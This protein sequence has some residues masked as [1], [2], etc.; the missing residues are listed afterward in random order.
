MLPFR[1]LFQLMKRTNI[2]LSFVGEI[3][4]PVVVM[5]AA[6]GNKLEKEKAKKKQQLNI[7]HLE[8]G[9]DNHQ[10]CISNRIVNILGTELRTNRLKINFEK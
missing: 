6:T 8:I 4:C 10:R 9:C 5:S 2:V 7:Y 1:D 3:F